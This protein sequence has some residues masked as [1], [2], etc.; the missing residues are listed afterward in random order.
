MLQ[1]EKKKHNKHDHDDVRHPPA[2]LT[3]GLTACRPVSLSVCYFRCCF[4]ATLQDFGLYVKVLRVCVG[5]LQ[6]CVQLP[7]VK[8]I[9][10]ATATTLW[11]QLQRR[12]T[13]DSEEDVFI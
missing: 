8:C 2:Y 12:A 10:K 5:K 3:A 6:L 4:W 11:Q 13:H 9:C 7:A 1:K